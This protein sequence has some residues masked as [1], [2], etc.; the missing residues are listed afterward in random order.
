MPQWI[1][2]EPRPRW[3]AAL[4]YALLGE[5]PEDLP[6]PGGVD[7]DRLLADLDDHWPGGLRAIREALAA[8]GVSRLPAHRLPENLRAGLPPAQLNS[9]L[10]ALQQRLGLGGAPRV[11][12]A[13]PLDADERRLQADVPPHHEF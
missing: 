9:A 8:A 13:R 6:E 11:R 7:L 5:A 2:S 10:I 12:T 1:V 4:S 3:H